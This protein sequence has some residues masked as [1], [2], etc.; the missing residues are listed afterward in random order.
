MKN[1]YIIV[2]EDKEDAKN[3]KKTIEDYLASHGAVCKASEGEFQKGKR[4]TLISDL[5]KQ[6]EC[7]I[8]LGG[9]GTL[10]QRSGR[11]RDPHCRDQYGRPGIP[12]T[13]RAKG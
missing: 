3:V 8:T 11:Q 1:F 13:D 5:P 9:D 4:F 2:N 6:T 10:I 7:V 12:D